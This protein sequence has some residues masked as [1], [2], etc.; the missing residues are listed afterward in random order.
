MEFENLLRFSKSNA[1]VRR[2]RVWLSERPR[3]AKARRDD[4]SVELPDARDAINRGGRLS[5]DMRAP[6]CSR[7]RASRIPVSW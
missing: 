3:W 5:S 2:R 6:S 7:G 4:S 1:D